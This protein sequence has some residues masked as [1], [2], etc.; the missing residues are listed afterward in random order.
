MR[1]P[2]CLDP[3]EKLNMN[4]MEFVIVKR[5]DK[6]RTSFL[7]T[8]DDFFS[9]DIYKEIEEKRRKKT[10]RQAYRQA[11]SHRFSDFS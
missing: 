5:E 6:H 11:C 3:F 2:I 10:T 4:K 9:G 8:V 7:L 1:P